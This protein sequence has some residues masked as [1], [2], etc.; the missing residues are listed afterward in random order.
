MTNGQS[1]Q[2]AERANSYAERV[3]SGEIVACKWIKRA[4]HRHL[5]DLKSVG[6]G[7]RWTFDPDQVHKVCHFAEL[8]RHEKG[9]KQGERFILEDFQVWLLSQIFG[10][11]DADTGI[12]KHREAFLL[13]PRG[14]GKS[15]L[16]AIIG[17]YMAF[18]DGEKGA[19]VYCG[20][21]SEDQAHEVFR[22]AK[23]MVEQ[24]ETLQNR[25]G[26]AP[27]AKSIYQAMTRSRFRP[28]IRKPKD[29]AS[30][31]CAILDELHQ[32]L[33]AE[34]Y[35]TFRTGANK[36]P[37][38]L[39]LIISTAGVTTNGPCH[40]KQKEV[41]KV[42]EGTIENERLFGAIYT[43]D[44]EVG[45]TSRDALVMANPNLGV[46]NDEESL[47]LD[48]AEA[49]RNPA[50]QNIF[51]CKHLNQWMSATSSWMNM[52]F[53][54]K[55]YDPELTDEKVKKF[56][57]WLGCDLASKLDLSAV[58]RVHRQDINGKPHYYCRTRT[59]L[60]EAR[61]KLPENQHYQAWSKRGFLTATNGASI[62]YSVIE[63]DAIADCQTY[64]VQQFAY[65]QRYAD[66]TSQRI[67]EATGIPRVEVTPSSA[68]LSPAMKEL[69]AAIYDGRF[70]HDNDPVLKWCL[71]NV[72]TYETS[73]GNYAMPDKQRPDNKID[74]AISLFI[75]MS[76]CMLG[77]PE[78]PSE[79]GF[80][81]V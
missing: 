75:A 22:P 17:L 81:I 39:I 61:V 7:Y 46:S 73:A 27:A 57:A 62:D 53:W 69:E 14:N 78:Q 9:A 59:Y 79:P 38:S 67:S 66:Q 13:L 65:D 35:D 54:A 37:N 8:M 6:P 32:A 12:R 28:V 56:P 40:E 43:I 45:W 2:Y 42:L 76:R 52:E 23:A 26:I 74:V 4:C 19:E 20:A 34:Q 10:W 5:N 77:P 71:S 70:H 55:C 72:T 21:T 30:V 18:F 24:D 60:P 1:S 16:A 68:A 50:K 48:Q 47:L 41:E 15:P 33:N 44:P 51:R 29:G 25:F 49:V 58:V 64:Q 3:C 63:A 36:R 11:V 31:Y 80:L